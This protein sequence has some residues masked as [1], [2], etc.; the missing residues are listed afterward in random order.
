MKRT[1]L[2]LSLRVA[3]LA[4]LAVLPLAGARPTDAAEPPRRNDPFSLENKAPDDQPAP[5]LIGPPDGP[6]PRVGRKAETSADQLDFQASVEPK[7]V[8]LGETVKLK[9]TGTP[10]AGYHTYPLTQRAA[11]DAQSESQL[12][13]IR[14]QDTEGLK[15]LWPVSE[16][17]P[18]SE[19]VQGVGDFLV[20]DKP[21]EWTQDVLLLTDAKPDP[22]TGKLTLKFTVHAQACDNDKCLSPADFP[23]EVAI[24]VKAQPAVALTP[25]LQAR[26]DQPPPAIAVVPAGDGTGLPSNNILALLLASMGAA[27]AMLLTPCVF[28]M[29]P[30]TVSFFLHQS[31]KKTGNPLVTAS[32]Y[33]GTIIVVLALSVLLLGHLVIAL[34]NSVWLNLGL[35][36]LLMFFALSLFGMYEIELPSWLTRF[37]SS[38]EGK[39]GYVGAVFMALTFT[40]TSFTCTGPFLGPLL[41]TTK[42]LR[43]STLE[44][45]L[46]AFAYSATFAAP[47]FV[48][49]LF[50]RLLKALPKSGGW[51]NVVKVVM[52]F[53]ELAAAL[54][55]LANTDLLWHPASPW[56]F[57]YDAVLCAWIALAV[58]CGL[59][60]F[61]VFRLPHDSPV[62]HLSVPRMVAGTIFLGLAV[63]M[64]PALW[65]EPPAGVVGDFIAANLP[66]DTNNPKNDLSWSQDYAEAW[67][68]A[69]REKKL[70][71]IDFTGTNCVNCRKNEFRVF[72]KAD[73]HDQLKNYVLVRLYTDVVQREGL[74]AEQ[75]AAEAARNAEWQRQTFGNASNPYYAVLR[76]DLTAPMEQDGKLTGAVLAE[77]AGTITDRPGFVQLLKGPQETLAQESAAGAAV[78]QK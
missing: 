10:H 74:S 66:L 61:G 41:V 63:Y 2:P 20:F 3:L 45:V 27:V 9:I 35:G 15:P 29:I 34:A 67:A 11:G 8:R 37:T 58:G 36:L 14:Y 76:P 47:F 6:G 65:R 64:T 60:L 1:H 43:L 48:L 5:P 38:R 39:G 26:L 72:P 78:A 42:E 23:L 68:R 18:R 7:E 51:L 55:F 53:L 40:I 56:V 49:A 4:A 71:F 77:Y 19:T 30:I 73:V 21:F 31:Q 17:K 44:L 12:C 50:P 25:E 59:Y 54:K 70:I 62:E 24:G 22:K 33:C 13:K 75:A 28:P 32:V 16:P 52:G 46:A 57:N 69:K